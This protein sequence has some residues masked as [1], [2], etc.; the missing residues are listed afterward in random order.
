MK[1][2]GRTYKHVFFISSLY[3][4][5]AEKKYTCCFVQHLK[6]FLPKDSVEKNIYKA[7]NYDYSFTS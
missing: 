3:S 5:K 1:S 6:Y 7:K 2:S 4:S